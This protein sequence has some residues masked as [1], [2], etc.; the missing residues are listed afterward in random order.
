M[1]KSYEEDKICD[2]VW[3]AQ[4]A[5]VHRPMFTGP[6]KVEPIL[7]V[8]PRQNEGLDLP[9]KF[10]KTWST[11]MK[12]ALQGGDLLCKDEACSARMR[13]ALQGKEAGPHYY[14][15]APTSP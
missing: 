13:L 11:R 9:T 5:H 3:R 12:L 14:K 8:S 1:V 7:C 2:K 15:K 4:E 10:Q 6:K